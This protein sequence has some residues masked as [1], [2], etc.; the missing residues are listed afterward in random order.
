MV[1]ELVLLG[2]E[3]PEERAFAGSVGAAAG[4]EL[5]AQVVKGTMFDAGTGRC[6]VTAVPPDA[7]ANTL[8]TAVKEAVER[9]SRLLVVYLGGQFTWDVRRRRPV[10]VTAGS[11]R[12]NA[13]GRGLAWDWVVSA[14]AHGA[15]AARGE[16]LLVVD[17][18]VGAE[19]WASAAFDAV[20]VRLWG[21]LQPYVPPRWGRSGTPGAV[22][23]V[24]A[25]TATAGG[26]AAL[27]DRAVREG[28]P[29]QPAVL[30]PAALHSTLEARDAPGSRWLGPPAAS[31]LLLRNRAVLRG[32]LR[33]T[34]GEQSYPSD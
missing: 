31:R 30:D 24:G 16:S 10:L 2:A 19:A 3:C 15:G 5:F 13:H 22:T 25:V 33:D 27:L 28:L 7:D 8:L 11:G 18:V 21:R 1:V 26:F 9:D 12:D 32:V 29:G 14:L 34:A 17:A 20:G 4:G 23:G 6:Q